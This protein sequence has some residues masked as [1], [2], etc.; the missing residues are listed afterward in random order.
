MQ[1][2]PICVPNILPLPLNHFDRLHSP[3]LSQF[4]T[5]RNSISTIDPFD[6]M[7]FTGKSN[8]S[9]RPI[10]N[11]H[12]KTPSL[13]NFLEKEPQFPS[14]PYSKS[15]N[16]SQSDYFLPKI[17]QCPLVKNKNTNK[18][19]LPPLLSS[20]NTFSKARNVATPFF[21]PQLI[22]AIENHKEP[23]K[24]NNNFSKRK[25]NRS[26][27]FEHIKRKSLADISFGDSTE[28]AISIFSKKIL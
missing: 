8:P 26:R 14:K 24:I 19:T 25:V 2:K 7:K 16:S 27:F 10:I 11:K 28:P 20:E 6:N 22:I 23:A 3:E 15:L 12:R 18:V 5:A 13:T 9:L 4:P 17:F 1:K 21:K